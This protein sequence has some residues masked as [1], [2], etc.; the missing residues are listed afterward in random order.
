MFKLSSLNS[1][2]MRVGVDIDP[3][4]PSGMRGILE[5]LRESPWTIPVLIGSVAGLCVFLA[6]TGILKVFWSEQSAHAESNILIPCTNTT[7]YQ[8]SWC[9][10]Q[11]GLAVCMRS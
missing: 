5:A 6:I 3:P 1:P 7:L 2:K 11:R 8:R 4:A 9:S 10:G